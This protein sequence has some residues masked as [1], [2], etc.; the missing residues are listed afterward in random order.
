ML[1]CPHCQAEWEAFLDGWLKET[2]GKKW[3]SVSVK[4]KNKQRQ[5]TGETQPQQPAKSTTDF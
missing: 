5:Q 4:A 3:L 2:N 1:Q